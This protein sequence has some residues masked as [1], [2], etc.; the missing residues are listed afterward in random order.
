LAS[1]ENPDMFDIQNYLDRFILNEEGMLST[2]FP[3]AGPIVLV[4]EE[5]SSP[6]Q[7]NAIEELTKIAAQILREKDN[8]SKRKE[9]KE[10]LKGEP[11]GKLL[12]RG[13]EVK[14]AKAKLLTEL[15][16]KIT[17]GNNLLSSEDKEEVDNFL[18]EFG[19]FLE[20]YSG[21][22]SYEVEVPNI[23]T[24]SGNMM[25]IVNEEVIKRVFEPRKLEIEKL[26]NQLQELSERLGQIND[27]EHEEE[28]EEIP[29]SYP[30]DETPITEK[31]QS[32][33]INYLNE[34]VFNNFGGSTDNNNPNTIRRIRRNNGL[35]D[36]E[37]ELKGSGTRG[38][39]EDI[40]ARFVKEICE[41]IESG[42]GIDNVL[43]A[44][45]Q[46]VLEKLSDILIQEIEIDHEV[47]LS[48]EHKELLQV[49][50]ASGKNTS[51]REL[52]QNKRRIIGQ[53][54]ADENNGT[55]FVEEEEREDIS[56]ADEAVKKEAELIS[57]AMLMK[58]WILTFVRIILHPTI[59]FF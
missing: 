52:T 9:L 17:T 54:T 59:I 4:K 15:T 20:D 24:G 30:R 28:T 33:V 44:K 51:A 37:I 23:I 29:I 3:A 31:E 34:L 13:C 58:L 48:N 19:T 55:E 35:E 56:P 14:D 25:A 42:G 50:L 43:Q 8:A 22:S 1:K 21:K 27:E 6:D 36:Y 5:L 12:T 11:L 26:E 41:K 32:K 38:E 10:K 49:D 39:A 46:E 16:E 2:Y 18:T 7:D 53:M 57:L 40:R 45:K 47:K